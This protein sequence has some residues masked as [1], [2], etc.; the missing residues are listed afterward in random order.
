M[1]KQ[2]TVSF[3][4]PPSSST[5]LVW[6]RAVARAVRAQGGPALERAVTFGEVLPDL[7]GDLFLRLAAQGDEAQQ[8]LWLQEVVYQTPA[9]LRSQADRVVAEQAGDLPSVVR[10]GMTLYLSQTG[11]AVR[12][13]LRRPSDPEGQRVPAD[14]PLAGPDDLLPLLPLRAPLYRAGDRPDGL[15]EW[16]LEELLGLS[17]R[18]EVWRARPARSEGASVVLKFWPEKL[19]RT[20]QFYQQANQVLDA[21]RDGALPGVVNLLDVY[22]DRNPGCLK[23][24]LVEGG[25][26][27]GLVLKWGRTLAGAEPGHQPAHIEQ[28]ARLMLG[29][30]HVLAACHGLAEPLVHGDL[31]LAHLLLQPVPNGPLLLRVTDHA[32]GPL[33]ARQALSDAAQEPPGQV[34]LLSWRGAYTPLYASPQVSEGLPPTPADDVYS[35]GVIAYQMLTA[36]PTAF[37]DLDWNER[38]FRLHTPDMLIQL[39]QHCLDEEPD[40]RIRS[41]DLVQQLTE[42]L[43]PRVLGTVMGGTPT[44]R[45]KDSEKERRRQA[46]ERVERLHER[47]RQLEAQHDYTGAVLVLEAVPDRLRDTALYEALCQCRDRVHQLDR[48]ITAALR[49][50]NHTGLRPKVEELLRLKPMRSELKQLLDEDLAE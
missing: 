16:Q 19:L 9:E 33:A 43:S 38:L 47:A 18:G 4:R 2:E 24:E 31:K 12:Q 8:R 6:L 49:A 13:F 37:V 32:L 7:A 41:Q 22:P 29:L 17:S 35:L 39:V 10:T 3:D 11:T 34:R 28:A 23:S 46:R 26:V 48:E 1:S 45:S 15:E 44:T 30:A 14:L 5:E 21:V 36:N 20:P 42:V 40:Q 27:T 50:R 25:S